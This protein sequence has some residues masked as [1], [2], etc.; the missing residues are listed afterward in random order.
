MNTTTEII[1][2][3]PTE[4]GILTDTKRS[5]L[6]IKNSKKHQ[7]TSAKKNSHRNFYNTASSLIRI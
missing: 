2:V 4:F 1:Q 7:K 6:L 3:N 5:V